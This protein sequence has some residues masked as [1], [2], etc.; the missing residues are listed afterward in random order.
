MWRGPLR[1]KQD[2]QR[3]HALTEYGIDGIPGDN[4][5]VDE[6]GRKRLDK[7]V[8]DMRAAGHWAKTTPTDQV[9]FGIRRIVGIIKRGNARA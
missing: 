5:D 4:D 8:D 3:I 7:A 2:Q 1:A 9:R 6:E